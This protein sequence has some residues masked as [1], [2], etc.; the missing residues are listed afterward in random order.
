MCREALIECGDNP[1]FPALRYL[2]VYIEDKA[3]RPLL[4]FLSNVQGLR[5]DVSDCGP[6]QT[7][8][9]YIMGL[10]SACPHLEDLEFGTRHSSTIS[11][12]AFLELASGCPLLRRLEIGDTCDCEP[13]FNDALIEKLS[14]RWKN[15]AV[16]SLPFQATLTRR[17]LAHLARNC[18][19]LIELR[20]MDDVLEMEE[21]EPVDMVPVPNLKILEMGQL[22]L[23]LNSESEAATASKNTIA[24]LDK[25][26]PALQSFF[27]NYPTISRKYHMFNRLVAEHLMQTR[28]I[29]PLPP[30]YPATS[31]AH[32]LHRKL[33]APN[34]AGRFSSAF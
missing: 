16:L 34:S 5:L 9:P 3:L 18:P 31:V 17:S 11:S 4:P 21:K 7:Q 27:H 13:D 24:V 33:L 28:P 12:A 19:G 10:L 25:W 1:I 8:K 6:I 20:V 23:N 15:L 22:N 26:F 30:A 32:E 14:S 2:G 29:Q